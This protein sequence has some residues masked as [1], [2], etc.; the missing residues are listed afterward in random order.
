MQ[1]TTRASDSATLLIPALLLGGLLALIAG[2]VGL[3]RLPETVTA[4]GVVAPA[5]TLV[6]PRPFSY[7]AGGEFLRDGHPVEAPLI[8]VE[9]PAPLEITT[10]E[11]SAADYALCVADGGCAAAQPR[12]Q[13]AGDVPVTGVS[14]ED[15]TAYAKWLSA[16]TGATWRLPTL[17]EWV[18]AAGEQAVD[19]ALLAATDPT[20]PADRWLALY[21]KE[22]TL[23]TGG[24]QA[25][26]VARGTF[27]AN[28]LGVADIDGPVWEWT[29][30]CNSRTVLDADDNV[31]SR[32]ESCGVKLL[33]GRHRT[34]MS[35]FIRDGRSGGCSVGAPPDNL[36]F[37]LVREPGWFEALRHRIGA[38]VRFAA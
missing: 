20:N 7:R 15:A 13:G 5:T 8:A 29:S 10:F 6:P 17:E 31:L 27:G 3:L 21:V 28:T 24:A 19:P 14:F 9:A 23:G 2:Q 32:V 33:E 12:R 30:T 1:A 22:A 16:A 18:F 37:R 38:L 35:Y 25:M 4:T 34:A 11:I 26:P 36:G